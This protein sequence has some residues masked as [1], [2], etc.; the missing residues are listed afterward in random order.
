MLMINPCVFSDVKPKL[1]ATARDEFADLSNPN[2]MI[3]FYRRLFPF[4]HLF[5][6]LNQDHGMSCA[7]LT[8][9]AVCPCTDDPFERQ[10]VPTKNFTNREF[11]FTLRGGVYLRYQSFASAEEF[12]KAVV[13]TNPSR[14]EIGPVYSANVRYLLRRSARQTGHKL[15][16]Y[17]P[18]PYVM[19]SQRIT[20]R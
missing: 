8:L 12:K 10:I 19:I 3:T 6:W 4:K 18:A 13:A 16:L 2:N 15:T 1:G 7:T 9:C 20:R 14:F 17:H 11:A 5:H